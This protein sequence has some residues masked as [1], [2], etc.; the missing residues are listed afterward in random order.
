M[1]CREVELLDRFEAARA[2][3]AKYG[4]ADPS[5]DK[6]W[7]DETRR[8]IADMESGKVQG[9]LLEETLAKARKITGQ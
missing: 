1:L 4:E 9:I 3:G 8:R 7:L 2:A 6:A 5:V